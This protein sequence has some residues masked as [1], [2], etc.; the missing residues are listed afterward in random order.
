[1]N[2]ISDQPVTMEIIKS[3]IGNIVKLA[4]IHLGSDRTY[5]TSFK[6]TGPLWS[7]AGAY[8]GDGTVRQ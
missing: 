4:Q 8:T 5:S 7:A 1:M 2:Y 6:A 3:P